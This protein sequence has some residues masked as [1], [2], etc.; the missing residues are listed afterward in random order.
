MKSDISN[1]IASARRHAKRGSDPELLE[2]ADAIREARTGAGLT[3]DQLALV[4]GVSRDTIIALENGRRGV[5][6]GN[7]LR[8]MKNLGLSLAPKVRD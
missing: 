3:Q 2:L 6:L 5:S 4:S 7:A 1:L 8:V